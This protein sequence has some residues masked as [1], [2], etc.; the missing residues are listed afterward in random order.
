MMGIRNCIYCNDK[1]INNFR[2]FCNIKCKDRF[3]IIDYKE[4][5]I[6]KISPIITM[7][8]LSHKWYTRQD[9]INLM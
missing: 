3:L 8:T 4:H 9:R 1:I 2:L 6:N 7:T 5:P